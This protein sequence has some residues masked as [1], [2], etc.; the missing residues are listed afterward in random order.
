VLEASKFGKDPMQGGAVRGMN[1]DSEVIVWIIG[2][3]THALI[4]IL[5]FV[6]LLIS[7]VLA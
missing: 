4:S 7:I 3:M 1:L 5:H 2:G 6:C